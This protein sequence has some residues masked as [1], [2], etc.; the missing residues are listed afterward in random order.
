MLLKSVKEIIHCFSECFLFGINTR[1]LQTHGAVV[2]SLAHTLG[3]G[4][5]PLAAIAT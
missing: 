3:A 4:S 2:L 1:E 5:C